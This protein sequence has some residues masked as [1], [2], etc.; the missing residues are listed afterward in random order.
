MEKAKGQNSNFL[1]VVFLYDT[2][3]LETIWCMQI[4]HMPN[5][6]SAVRPS[7]QV[8]VVYELWLVIYGLELSQTYA[9]FKFGNLWGLCSGVSGVAR[10][11]RPKLMC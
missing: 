7:F 1:H 4:L 3:N 2:H 6:F 11:V 8:F 9:K 10:I 5:K